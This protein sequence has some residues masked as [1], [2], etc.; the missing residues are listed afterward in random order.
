MGAI[1]LGGLN[2]ILMEE[3]AK[4]LGYD[5]SNKTYV[6]ER[7]GNFPRARH[8]ASI[9][10]VCAERVPPND[11]TCILNKVSLDGMH[12]CMK[13]YGARIFAAIACLLGCIY[14]Q[15]FIEQH[16]RNQCSSSCNDQFM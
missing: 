3:N 5:T 10:Q 7:L 8:A 1:D 14:N 9:A 12:F 11:V 6:T 13:T 2:K 4:A 15:N 16:E